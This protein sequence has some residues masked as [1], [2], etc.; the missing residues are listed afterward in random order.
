LK[1]L[2]CGKMKNSMKSIEVI[3]MDKE[4]H[5]QR[6]R[7]LLKDKKVDIDPSKCCNLCAED[8]PAVVKEYHHIFGKAN[9]DEII[10]LCFNCHAKITARQNRLPKNIRKCS[11]SRSKRAFKLCSMSALQNRISEEMMKCR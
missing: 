7:K 10:L 5:Q 11:N 2:K 4:T 3:S 1:L 8:D 6:L 9:S